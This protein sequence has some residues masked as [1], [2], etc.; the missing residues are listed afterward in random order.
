MSCVWVAA[1]W[2]CQS[3]SILRTVVYE[4]GSGPCR[5]DADAAGFISTVDAG[6][7]CADG[8][9]LHDQPVVRDLKLLQS[10]IRAGKGRRGS[11]KDVQIRLLPPGTQI[12]IKTR[13]PGP[14]IRP[15]FRWAVF[16][17]VACVL[18]AACWIGNI[19][20]AALFHR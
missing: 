17:F 1:V 12:P 16:L 7:P 8:Y 11:A 18:I 3:L 9:R 5:S 10:S 14:A 19:I 6:L 15:R 2:W 13:A 4:C 20:G